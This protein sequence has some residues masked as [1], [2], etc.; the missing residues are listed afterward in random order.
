MISLL[1]RRARWVLAATLALAALA[2]FLGRG[3]AERMQTSPGANFKD[4][5]A[6]SVRAG[7]ELQAAAGVDPDVGIIALGLPAAA[8]RALAELRASPAI[9]SATA[10]PGRAGTYVAGSFRPLGDEERKLAT[11]RLLVA[12]RAL[13]GLE[14]GGPAVAGTQISDTVQADLKRA[15][16]IAFPLLILLSFWVF[17]GVVAA[18][19]PPLVGGATVALTLFLLQ[20]ASEVS[21]LSIFALNLVTGLGLGLSIDYS[22]FV[23]SRYREELARHGPGLE[24]LRRT[25]ATAGRTVLFSALTVAAALAS[26]LVFPQRFLWSMGV[27]GVLVS[28]AAAAVALVALPAALALLGSRVNALAPARWQRPVERGG[29]YRLSRFVMRRPAPVAALSATLL[30]LLGLPFLGVRFTGVDATALPRSESA[31]RVADA[32]AREPVPQRFSPIYVAARTADPAALRAYVARL[33]ALPDVQ[34]VLLPRRVGGDLWRVDAIS[35]ENALADSSQR[36]VGRI[37]ALEPPFPVAVGGAAA[38]FRDQQASLKAHLPLALLLVA[39]TTLALL[40]ALTHSVL[41]PLK[42][43]LLN[44]L[45]LSAAFGALVLIFQDGHL[46][47]LLGF[48]SQGALESTQPI[49]LFALAFGLATDYGVFL[50]SRIKEAR[51]AGETNREA[52]ALGVERTGRIVTAA[53]LLFCVAIGAFATSRI[54]FIKELAVGTGIAVFLD[55]TLVRALLVPSLMALLGEWNWWAPSLRRKP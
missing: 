20:L 15:E 31:R 29:W 8:R 39:L 55:A 24:A 45:T 10:V 35:R 21:P 50:L 52:V 12:L 32:V 16:L 30:I 14:L 2:G 44:L 51:D 47:G 46:E 40:F 37:R 48:E 23:I 26:L 38:S 5:G 27:G 7:D 3:V 36:L 28:L 9:A 42:A 34:E 25:Y 54:V 49:L 11:E 22:L 18:L 1:H 41:L 19:L 4:P 13:P 43:L 53:M 33:R 17:R 6:E